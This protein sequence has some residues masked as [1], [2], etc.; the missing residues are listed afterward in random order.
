MFKDNSSSRKSKRNSP[1]P[2]QTTVIDHHRFADSFSKWTK[3][4][5]LISP[6]NKKRRAFA[7]QQ[8]QQQQY[9][10]SS[11]DDDSSFSSTEEQDTDSSDDDDKTVVNNPYYTSIPKSHS[12]PTLLKRESGMDKLK[13][14]H[15][16]GMYIPSNDAVNDGPI[17]AWH[18]WNLYRSTCQKLRRCSS[19]PLLETIHLRKMLVNLQP[20]TCSLPVVVS[21]NI[22]CLINMVEQQDEEDDV[23]LGTLLENRRFLPP[24]P[25]VL[26]PMAR[27][28]STGSTV[29][30]QRYPITQTYYTSQVN[31]N[32]YIPPPKP[33]H[34]Y[35]TMKIVSEK[36]R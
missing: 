34:C 21:S 20:K 36:F 28:Y 19:L 3:V 7:Q 29:F 14:L 23:P 22:N 12:A 15:R 6:P 13:Q 30:C 1:P 11:S 31:T 17:D 33:Y 24:T 27:N 32:Y 5:Q 25:S 35:N 8:Q 18:Q 16:R 10:W 9:R 2:L 4:L 26:E